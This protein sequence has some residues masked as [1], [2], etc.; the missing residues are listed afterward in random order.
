MPCIAA[1]DRWGFKSGNKHHGLEVSIT[2]RWY[3]SSNA[4][5][6][7]QILNTPVCILSCFLSNYDRSLQ[8]WPQIH[9]LLLNLIKRYVIAMVRLQNSVLAGKTTNWKKYV[10]QVFQDQRILMLEMHLVVIKWIVTHHGLSRATKDKTYAICLHD[11]SL[12]CSMF[13]RPF[14]TS[15]MHRRQSKDRSGSWSIDT[16]CAP[17]M[18]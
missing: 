10:N 6:W 14:Y 2:I 9:K 17:L 11:Y 12:L 1:N 3:M 8:V 7:Y 15:F 18:V 5:Y 4:L 13:N 16:E